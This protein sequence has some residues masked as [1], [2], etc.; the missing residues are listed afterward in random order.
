MTEDRPQGTVVPLETAPQ[1]IDPGVTIGHVHNDLELTWDRPF[2]AWPQDALGHLQGLFDDLDL[3][4][5][6]AAG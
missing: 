2:E 3:D 6:A 1:P 5:L 4:A